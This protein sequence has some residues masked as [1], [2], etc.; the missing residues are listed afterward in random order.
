MLALKKYMHAMAS[1][2]LSG[3]ELLMGSSGSCCNSHFLNP[4]SV[5]SGEASLASGTLAG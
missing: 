3:G 2:M 5:H 4:E 1:S